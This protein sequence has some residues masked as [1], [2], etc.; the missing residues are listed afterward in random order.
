ML[1]PVLIT[2]AALAALLV[3]PMVQAP[4]PPVWVPLGLFA[5]GAVWSWTLWFL[6]SARDALL[7]GILQLV[8]GGAFAWWLFGLSGY[9]PP[10][11]APRASAEAPDI[12]AVRVADGAEFRLSAQRGRP[13]VLVFFRGTW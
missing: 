13:V 9:Q 2:L 12:E 11:G 4:D 3:P 5:I 1:V 7:L 8:V 10:D 6:R